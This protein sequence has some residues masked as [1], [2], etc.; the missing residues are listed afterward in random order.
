MTKGKKAKNLTKEAVKLAKLVNKEI[1]GKKGQKKVSRAKGS[2]RLSGPQAYIN[3]LNDP[4]FA[5]PMKLGFG[6][7]SPTMRRVAWYRL[8]V[9]LSTNTAFAVTFDHTINTGLRLYLNATS[10][11]ALGTPALTRNAANMDQIGA[12]FQSARVIAAALR[13]TAR[14]ATTAVRGV[15]GGL[16]LSSENRTNLEAA[17]F[18]GVYGN[19]ATRSFYSSAP[20][21]IG[22]QVGYRPLDPSDF[23]FFGSRVNATTPFDAASSNHQLV[24]IGTAWPPSTTSIEIQVI[25]HL[26]GVAGLDTV[27]EQD[28]SEGYPDLTLD[29]AS[30]ALQTAGE[31][32]VPTLSGIELLDFGLSHAYSRAALNGFGTGR[33]AGLNSIGMQNSPPIPNPPGPDLRSVGSSSTKAVSSGNGWTVV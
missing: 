10:A 31:P 8:N 17:T 1:G 20:G 28:S 4:F 16:A 13:V 5:S 3:L 29:S 24:V 18:D 6:T 30:T 22:G 32:V 27:G 2:K 11:A 33:S 7:F 23:E 12:C 21:E 15:M 19:G 9:G 14:Y 25:M 26:E